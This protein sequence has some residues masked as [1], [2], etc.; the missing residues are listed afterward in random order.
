MKDIYEAVRNGPGWGKVRRGLQLQPPMDSP[1]RSCK[2][3]RVLRP[4]TLLAIVYDDAGESR[5]TAAV[6]MENPYCSCKRTRDSCSPYGEPL[7]QL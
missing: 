2:L 5:P 1:C 4:K 7:L 3:T 6:P